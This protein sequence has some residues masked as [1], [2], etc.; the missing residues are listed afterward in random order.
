MKL[1]TKNLRVKDAPEGSPTARATGGGAGGTLYV[2]ENVGNPVSSLQTDHEV[3]IS[4]RQSIYW[5]FE[6][7]AG[8]TT[9]PG[10]VMDYTVTL[11]T[12]VSGG[13]VRTKTWT[14]IWVSSGSFSGYNAELFEAF[15][16]VDAGD[17]TFR[18]TVTGTVSSDIEVTSAVF[19]MTNCEIEMMDSP[20]P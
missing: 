10:S 11:S 9:A 20:A 3:T 16:T 7:H 19:V 12:R 17:W 15:T 6:L 1:P 5:V 18:S 4:E 13:E 14:D 2:M 8:R